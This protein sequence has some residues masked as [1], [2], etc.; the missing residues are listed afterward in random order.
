MGPS[1]L[2]LQGLKGFPCSVGF[3]FVTD[4]SFVIAFDAAFVV[5]GVVVGCRLLLGLL[6]EVE[7]V[8]RLR[9]I[10]TDYLGQ[11]SLQVVIVMLIRMIR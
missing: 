2:G 7:V 9:V 6:L 8:L 1:A 3:A 10:G 5:V 11:I 4:F